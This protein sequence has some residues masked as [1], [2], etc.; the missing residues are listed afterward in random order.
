VDFASVLAAR[1]QAVLP[2]GFTVKAEQ[3]WVRVSHGD[4]DRVGGESQNRANST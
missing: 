3:G 2:E 1:L 4:D